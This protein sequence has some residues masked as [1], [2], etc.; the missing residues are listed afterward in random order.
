MPRGRTSSGTAPRPL[1]VREEVAGARHDP[2]SDASIPAAAAPPSDRALRAAQARIA[3]LEE[4]LTI[5]RDARADA[6][7]ALRR[8]R[9]ELETRRRSA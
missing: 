8:V 7:E 5:E 6:E 9:G 3:E 2:R 4:A 1:V